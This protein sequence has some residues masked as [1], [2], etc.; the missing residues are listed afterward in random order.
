MIS[1]NNTCLSLNYNELKVEFNAVTNVFMLEIAHITRQKYLG[2]IKFSASHT[3]NNCIEI[4]QFKP[5]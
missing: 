5:E 2:I 3:Q 4:E 1:G